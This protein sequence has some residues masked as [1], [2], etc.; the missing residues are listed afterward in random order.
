MFSANGV[1]A[2]QSVSRRGACL[3]PRAGRRT[4]RLPASPV[5]LIG[6]VRAVTLVAVVSRSERPRARALRPLAAVAVVPPA[7][8]YHSL[9]ATVAYPHL[10]DGGHATSTTIATTIT[11]TIIV[12]TITTTIS[13]IAISTAAADA[14]TAP[15]S[16]AAAG[17][18][19]TTSSSVAAATLATSARASAIAAAAVP[20]PTLVPRHGRLQ[21]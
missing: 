12:A 16:A 19:P 5:A 6:G 3:S 21:L 18:P 10:P 9:Y 17:R 14:T 20:S 4:G 13:A 1:P 7:T 11:I 15:T 8:V 2:G